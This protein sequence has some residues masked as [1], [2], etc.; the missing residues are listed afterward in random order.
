MYYLIHVSRYLE[1]HNLALYSKTRALQNDNLENNF[2][3]KQ[4]SSRFE[5]NVYY[6]KEKRLQVKS[7]VF[8]KRNVKCLL[9]VTVADYC[10]RQTQNAFIFISKLLEFKFLL[11]TFILKKSKMP[12]WFGRYHVK[13]KN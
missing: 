7:N 12:L 1:K 4:M 6:Q 5:V 10:Q 11:I 13:S 9:M 3:I 2:I 8:Q